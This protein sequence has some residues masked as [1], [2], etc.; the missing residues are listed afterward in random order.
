MATD[1]ASAQSNSDEADSPYSRF[2][3]RFAGRLVLAGLF[4]IAAL[5]YTAYTGQLYQD[6]NTLPILFLI[7]V[8]LGGGLY[9]SLRL[10]RWFQFRRS[11]S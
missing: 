10:A 4:T 1:S 5:A 8:G 6:N 2:Q 3:L 11:E 9:G 7:L